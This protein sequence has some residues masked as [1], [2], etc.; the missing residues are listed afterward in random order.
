MSELLPVAQAESL[1]AHLLE[2]LGTT[3]SLA[4]AGTRASL[5]DFLRSPST[6]LFRG[7]YVRLRLPFRPA[8]D[9]WRDRLEWYEG[10]PPYGHQAA[11]FR[12]LSSLGPDGSL[13]RPQPTLVTTGTG[14]GKTESF[15]YP[16]LDHVL[17]AKRA[18]VSGMKAIILYPMNA[19]AND[20]A[21]RLT[22]LLTTKDGL[23]GV[24]AALYTGQQGPERTRVSAAG[25]IT[26]RSVIRDSPPD[27]LLTN[28]KMLD[29]LLLRH[30]DA[31]LWSAS[32][33]SL[34]YLVLDEFH[35]YD[36]A[37]GTDVAMLI[38]RLGL[39]LKSHWPSDPDGLAAAGLA[40]EDVR[41]PLGIVTPV[42]TS[43]TL[44]DKGDPTAM[45]EFARTVFGEEFGEDAVVT[46]SRL[47]LA[48]WVGS[49][50]EDVAARRLVPIDVDP[51]VADVL[52]QAL[53]GWE[54]DRL[55]RLSD[56]DPDT[57]TRT[58]LAHLYRN[59]PEGA[60]AGDVV[61]PAWEV[62]DLTDDDGDAL[63]TLAK[64]HPL[65]GWLIEHTRDAT[66][67]A[68]L[69]RIMPGRFMDPSWPARA[70]QVLTALLSALSHLRKECGRGALSV[71][72]HLW[73]RELTRLN[74][75]ATG[76]AQFAWEDEG[77][78]VGDPDADGPDTGARHFP[79]LYC[80]HCGRS[81]WGVALAPTGSDLD[82]QDEGIRLRHLRGD[83]RFRALIHA[84][85]EGE[86]A[87]RGEPVENLWWFL[88]HERRLALKKPDES[89]TGD[90][91]VLPVLT[92][93]TDDAGGKPS[94]DDECPSCGQTDGIRF[95]GSAIATLLSVSLSSLFGTAQLDA[96][97]KKALVFTDSVQD[98]AHRAGFVQARSHA[99]TLRAVLRQAMSDEPIDLEALVDRVI[100][101]AGDD[102]K[103]RYRLLPPDLAEREKF[104]PFWQADTRA[105]VHYTVR[106]RVRRRLLLDVLMEHGLRSGV[107][108]T[109]E[110]TGTAVA[111]VRAEPTRLLAAARDAL[112]EIDRQG[113]LEGFEPT[114]TQLLAWVRGVL[115][116]MRT[117]GAIEHEWFKRFR[118]EDGNRWWITGGRK[119][120]EG[121]PGFGKGQS[122]PGFPRVGGSV[123]TKAGRRGNGAG[124]AEDLEPVA[125]PKGWYAA[126]TAKCLNVDKTEAGVLARLLMRRLAILDVVGT[127]P[128][129]S[130]GDTYHLSPR[131]VVVS[132]ADAGALARG[133]LS[134]EC[135]DCGSTLPGSATVVGQLAGAPCL[136]ARC[137]GRLRRHPMAENFYRRM[138]QDSDPARVVAREHTSMLEDEVRLRYETEFKADDP[139]P[140]APNVLVATPTLEMGIDI[141][142]L[143]TVMLS[144]LPRSVA[145]YLQR[146]GRAGRLTGNALTLAFVTARGDQLP[147]FA[148]P[149]T[150]VNGAVRPPATYLD[151]EEILRRQYVASIADELARRPDAPHPRTAKDALGSSEPGSY[152]GEIVAMSENEGR[153]LLDRFLGG[154]DSVADEVKDRLRAWALPSVDAATGETVPS[155]LARRCHDA[156]QRWQQRLET[157]N[158]RVTEI[159][160]AIN[161]ELR[162]KAES[163]AATDDD[164]RA[165]RTAVAA[166][167]LT[168]AQ[169]G[170]LQGEHWVATL[171]E[172]GLLPNYTLLDDSVTLEVALSWVDPDTQ[173]FRSEQLE[174][175]RGSAQALRDF[176]PGATFYARGYAIQID[177]LDLGRGDDAVRLWA[178]CPS[179]GYTQDVTEA[180][181]PGAAP[182]LTSCPRC[183]EDGIADVAQQ[184]EVVELKRVSSVIRR[185]EATI[186]DR[187]DE[188]ERERFT[189]R[190]LADVDPASVARQWFVKDY[191][192]GARYQRQMTIR[193]LNLGKASAQGSTLQVAGQGHDVA[194]FRVCRS[195]GKLDTSTGA[196]KASEHRPW[197]PLRKATKE[198]TRSV[199]L[200]RSLTTE[201]LVLRLPQSVTLGDDF[202][203]PS[204]RA[205]LLL[206]LQLRI[207]GEPDHLEVTDV[208]DPSPVAGSPAEALLLHDVVAGGTG[209][210]AELADPDAVWAM[211]HTAWRHLEA[212]PCQAQGK[213]ACERCLLPYA[214]HH[215]VG[216]VSRAT[217]ARHLK[218]IL[219]GVSSA[220]PDDA[221]PEASP[222]VVDTEEPEPGP[223]ESNI[224]LLF[225]KV[226]RDRLEKMG[227]T[228]TE[229]PGPTGNSWSITMPGGAH[230]SLEPQVLVPEAGTRPD[231]VLTSDRPGVPRTAIYTDGWAF[232]ASPGVNRLADDAQ[233]R[234]N[235]R[236]VGFQV[237]A[238]QW[239]DLDP[240]SPARPPHWLHPDASR[241]VLAQAKDRISPSALRLVSEPALELLM[242]WVQ[243]PDVDA[244]KQLAH[245][246]PALFLRAVTPTMLSADVTLSDAAL[247]AVDGDHPPA[248][249]RF[250]G[251]WKDDSLGVAL[252]QFVGDAIEIAVVL[253]DAPDALGHDHR[254]AWREWLRLSNL[255]NFREAPTAVATR[256]LV[257][258]PTSAPAPAPDVEQA[259]RE[260]A[261]EAEL[262]KQLAARPEWEEVH[263]YATDS[264]RRILVGLL[265]LAGEGLPAPTTGDEVGD[266]IPLSLT[267]EDRRVTVRHDDLDDDAVAWLTGEGWTVVEPE[268]AAVRSALTTH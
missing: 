251:T 44:G 115:E 6:G 78:L 181:A 157:L 10:F 128:M 92:H 118:E 70:E 33:R 9:G 62:P 104:A 1:R 122:A 268:P 77:V 72:V 168:K 130:G 81:G 242:T 193:W 229:K 154:F 106:E 64:A 71:D 8:D 15:L 67:L 66:D 218:S 256:S 63:L 211:L 183:G 236:D 259:E 201:G 73:T 26:D 250:G 145:S 142:D 23:A 224:E 148:D 116:H 198:E 206:A 46:E 102:K 98:A 221:V 119:R 222:W 117:R 89:D 86:R 47:P 170:E 263:E 127:H 52:G 244:R 180:G 151:A 126:W 61:E 75:A 246:L 93:R 69:A 90:G 22:E 53:G 241:D 178:C 173:D 88:V 30:A 165:L 110:A 144:S 12:R 137:T 80:R 79:A 37:Q 50:P 166:L 16:I 249:A 220:G 40:P 55:P 253:D 195:C 141:G 189:I 262:R 223:A 125:S 190:A 108:R 208:I 255:L 123:A 177:A 3:F 97:E 164:K 214:G 257:A 34:Q 121:M 59:R 196:N 163:P 192:F 24:T 41:R 82:T 203:V 17:R 209:Y 187:S 18:G 31:K 107:G 264:E 156:S 248:G 202:S 29:Q 95:L 42:A 205:A 2:Y 105:K 254:D 74:R 94:K 158:H 258:A 175:N 134:L 146:V 25:L 65:V 32:A 131:S 39:A 155:E 197:C 217:A 153:A 179:C 38:R 5:E 174:L 243:K 83:D 266:G 96:A 188:R 109:L 132:A 149:T 36:G 68:E 265:D 113:V 28:Y 21:K 232:H 7:P 247:A 210:L 160:T 231:F 207:G 19:L 171:E 49:A 260:S 99:L 124:A 194:L 135:S 252:R 112:D 85:V 213:L 227:A 219:L 176:A 215:E 51:V 161:G 54:Q 245:W 150:V 200:A 237:L 185:E 101:E 136:V 228:V 267:W 239:E 199:A 204:L 13:R 261:V 238:F 235:L 43:A 76:L 234:Q 138:Y 57:L 169:R 14:S 191:G 172:F 60:E 58:V 129:K 212:C 139:E 233:K 111:E 167:G 182:P 133:D 240:K 4:D 152:L 48:E 216:R 225:R 100:A 230:W 226:F 114:E 120:H 56:L 103:K 35:T 140:N 20:Q 143:S 159:E 87:E 184:V 162:A 11:A 45:L 27:I 147:R 91:D 186:D 84:P